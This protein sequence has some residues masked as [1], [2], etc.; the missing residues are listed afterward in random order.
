MPRGI[1]KRTIFKS[2]RDRFTARI[3]KRRSGCWEWTGSSGS[4]GHGEIMRDPISRKKMGTHRVAWELVNGP[5]PEGLCVLHKCDN[6]PCC[7]PEHL[8]LGTKRDNTN[9]M[10]AKG[11]LKTGT[12]LPQSKLTPQAVRFIRKSSATQAVLAAHYGVSQATISMVRNGHY[13]KA[14]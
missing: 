9:D 2:L 6:P 7:N 3:V 11:R 8:F 14:I 12:Q 10:V 13:W 5:I 4:M 1:Y